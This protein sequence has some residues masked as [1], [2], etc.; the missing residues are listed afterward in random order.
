MKKV[1]DYVEAK[2]V[3]IDGVD[4]KYY[5]NM[6]RVSR[7]RALFAATIGAAAAAAVGIISG[8]P[9]LS[10]GAFPIAES[11]AMPLMVPYFINSSVRRKVLNGSYF[12]DKS[13]REI[14]SIA[15]E[16]INEVNQFEEKNSEGGKSK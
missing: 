2:L 14:I 9:I 5:K 13:E 8:D 11:L 6:L 4:S 16:H 7:L 1:D 12:D 3:I 15:N 10:V